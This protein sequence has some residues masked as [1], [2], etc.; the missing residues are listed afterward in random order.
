MRRIISDADTFFIASGYQGAKESPSSGADVSH[1]GGQ[2]GF[3]EIEGNQLIFPDYRGNNHFNTL[4]NL[5]KNPKAGLT[6]LDFKNSSILY[7]TGQ[8]FIDFEL[9]SIYASQGAERV[10]RFRCEEARLLRHW[11][12]KGF[13]EAGIRNPKSN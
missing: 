5:I 13:V 9:N 12:R 2:P 11:L 8:A 1:R 6:F 4:G 3:V 7:L 10:I